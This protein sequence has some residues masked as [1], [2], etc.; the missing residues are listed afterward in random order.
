M[1]L[2]KTGLWR[3]GRS[4]PLASEPGQLG[5]FEQGQPQPAGRRRAE[6]ALGAESAEVKHAGGV[7]GGN[8]VVGQGAVSKLQVFLGRWVR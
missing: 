3:R 7:V 8:V 1:L 6:P 4:W 2:A 5:H